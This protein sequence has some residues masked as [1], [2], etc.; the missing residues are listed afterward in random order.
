M[1]LPFTNFTKKIKNTD[2]LMVKHKIVDVCGIFFKKI[3]QLQE[4]Q[5]FVSA[6]KVMLTQIESKIE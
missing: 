1:E 3:Y 5:L 2:M 4:N 6:N